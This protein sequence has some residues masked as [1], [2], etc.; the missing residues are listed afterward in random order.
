MTESNTVGGVPLDGSAQVSVPFLKPFSQVCNSV[1][2]QFTPSVETDVVI[3]TQVLN[4]TVNGF[5]LIAN[6]GATGAT[7]TFTYQAQGY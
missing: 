3:T 6:G 2:V 1:V 7:G 4:I 5:T